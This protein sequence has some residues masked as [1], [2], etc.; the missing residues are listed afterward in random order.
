MSIKVAIIGLGI[1]GRRMLEHMGLHPDFEPN[2]LWDPDTNACNLALDIN[3]QAQ[4]MD[5][6]NDAIHAAEA[7]EASWA[8][9]PL[10][11]W[12]LLCTV[13]GE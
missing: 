3:L 1:M 8:A 4:I 6:P 13:F 10:I 5:K 9:I 7:D 12:H 11:P 2:Y